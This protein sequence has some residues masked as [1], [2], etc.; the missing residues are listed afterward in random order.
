M[1]IVTGAAGF[2][3]ANLVKALEDRGIGPVI[4]VDDLSDG[5]KFHNL[6]D[7]EIYDYWDKDEFLDRIGRNDSLAESCRAV[8]HQGACSDTTEW[9]GRYIMAVNYDYSKMLLHFCTQRRIPF[10]Y[11]SS[12]SVYGMGPGFSEQRENEAPLNMYAYSKCLFDRYVRARAPFESQVVGLRYFNVYGPRE[13]HKA[14]MASIV[15]QLRNQL[16]DS[17]R[18][19]LFEGSDGFAAGEQRRD[20]IYVDD[21]AAVNIW[22]LQNQQ[23]QGVFNLGTG[24]SH[25]FNDVAHAVIDWHG[26]GEI[27]YVPFPESLRGHY[28][29]FT[30]ADMT[31]LR[32][33]GYEG[34]FMTVVEGVRRY[35]DVVEQRGI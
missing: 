20:F 2:I 18:V 33:A 35:M 10:I 31:A 9:D 3:G 24:T 32:E 12:A 22:C 34:R 21:V 15:W 25:S 30:E 6:A 11:A 23:C 28:Q 7:C 13:I 14:K 16:L 4:A 5:H 19:K 17:G 1:I 27:E 8:F 26:Y 29:S